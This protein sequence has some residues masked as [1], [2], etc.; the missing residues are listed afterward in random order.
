VLVS[1]I[2][3]F[4]WSSNRTFL[5]TVRAQIETIGSAIGSVLS[6]PV[7][8]VEAIGRDL[9]DLGRA[10]R[11]NR[12]L[13]QELNRLRDVEMRANA[14]AIKI[15][16]FESILNVG[17]SSGIPETK[18]AARAVSEINGP[19]VHS[20]LLD[21]GN[22]KGIQK[23]YAVMT[24]EGMLG[25]VIRVGP[26]SSRVLKLED[27]NSRIAVMS[28]RSQAR[29]IL[30]GN[31]TAYPALSYIRDNSDWRAGDMVVTSGDEGTLP[32]GLPIGT[33][34]A[35]E[36]ENLPVELFVAREDIDWVW[37]YPFEPFSAPTEDIPNLADDQN[38]SED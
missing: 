21:A 6:Y 24:A 9:G 26:R 34:L 13:K 29:A 30:T 3:L 14:L 2:L 32:A 23:G 8:A 31:N 20:V 1:I 4:S 19:F 12:R 33:V 18:I 28:L 35:G 38:G 7:K 37:V 36:K 16:R 5:G 22:G 11:E 27:L 15:S 10:H 25:H 17:V